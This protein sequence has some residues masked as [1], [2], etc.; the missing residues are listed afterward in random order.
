MAKQIRLQ[1][2]SDKARGILLKAGQ[3]QSTGQVK[4]DNTDYLKL[5]Q[6]FHEE[7]GMAYSTS[8]GWEDPAESFKCAALAMKRKS[9]TLNY[10]FDRHYT[11]H[12]NIRISYDDIGGAE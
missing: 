7:T 3:I 11:D 12:R 9:N 4:A 2:L 1:N 5:Y 10:K 6:D 8:A